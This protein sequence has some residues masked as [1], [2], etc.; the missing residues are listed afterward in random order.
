MILRC[1]GTK[2]QQH[3]E[4]EGKL[5]GI[6]PFAHCDTD[7]PYREGTCISRCSA[8]EINQRPCLRADYGGKERIKIA[9]RGEAEIIIRGMEALVKEGQELSDKQKCEYEFAKIFLGEV[10][11]RKKKES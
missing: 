6:I 9:N 11:K 7:C 10:T 8:L 5:Y 3:Y 4:S 1:G 2:E